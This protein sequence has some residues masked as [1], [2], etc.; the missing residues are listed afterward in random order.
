VQNKKD[1]VMMVPPGYLAAA[2]KDTAVL[3]LPSE[4]KFRR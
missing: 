2:K 1:T 3:I 4:L